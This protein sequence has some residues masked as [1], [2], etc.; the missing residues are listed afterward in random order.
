M[1]LTDTCTETKYVLYYFITM[2][3]TQSYSCIVVPQ[4]LPPHHQLYSL[5]LPLDLDL[6]A[7]LS[8]DLCYMP[9]SHF[10]SNCPN[11]FYITLQ[12]A[13]ELT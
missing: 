5:V 13:P 1:V 3:V 11:I 9:I 12:S 6:N 10:L 7:T 8:P 2:F 4:F